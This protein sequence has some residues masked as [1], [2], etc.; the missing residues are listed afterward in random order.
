VLNGLLV[1]QTPTEVTLKGADAIVRTF[2][3]SE[4]E[5]LQKVPVSLMPA[6]LQK[7]LTAEDLADVVEYMLTLKQAQKPTPP[8][9]P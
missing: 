6:D 2:K 3:R 7:L 8:R 4:I 5:S 9:R 1:S